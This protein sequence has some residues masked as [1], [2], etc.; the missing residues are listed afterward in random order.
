MLR[1]PSKQSHLWAKVLVQGGEAPAIERALKARIWWPRIC[2]NA[3]HN[4]M[5]PGNFS[6]QELLGEAVDVPEQLP[7]GPHWA[8]AMESFG[9]I[10]SPLK[11]HERKHAPLPNRWMSFN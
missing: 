11:M 10:A 6:T 9:G 4:P 8:R 7:G 1:G 2:C 3:S 5:Q